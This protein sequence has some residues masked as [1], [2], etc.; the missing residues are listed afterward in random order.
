MTD[1]VVVEI[2][3]KLGRDEARRRVD[4]G[5]GKLAGW[6]PGGAV[7]EH[8]WDADLMRFTLTAMGQQVDSVLDVREERVIATVNLPPFLA[9]FAGKLREKLEREGPRLLD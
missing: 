8:R 2:P 5:I 6:F 9:L 7:V 1:P 3:H 4:A